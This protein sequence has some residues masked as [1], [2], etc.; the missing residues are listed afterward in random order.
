[1]VISL[2]RIEG[3]ENGLCRISLFAAPRFEFEGLDG[4]GA[5]GEH[6]AHKIYRVRM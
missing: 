3:I 4:L 1:M 6:D 2:A 5:E